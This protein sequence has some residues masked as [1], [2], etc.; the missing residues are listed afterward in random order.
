MTNIAILGRNGM[1]GNTMFKYYQNCQT[2]ENT[3]IGKV[4][5][6]GREQF[7]ALKDSVDKLSD[8]LKEEQIDL[9]INAIGMIPQ[10]Y[11]QNETKN[12]K[13]YIRVN[14]VFPHLLAN[15]CEKLNIK[16][17]HI[18]TDCVFSG[19][20]DIT[21]SYTEDSDHDVDYIY[22]LT[23]SEG[24]P[25]NC[26]VVRTSIIGHELKHKKSLLEWVIS[27]TNK[28]INGYANHYWNG[29][30]CLQLAKILDP[31]KNQFENKLYHV[32][33]PN[34]VSKYELVN[35]INDIYKLNITINSFED[36]NYCNRTLTSLHPH[37]CINTIP[38][39][40]NQI[41][42]THDFGM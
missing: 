2:M 8:M 9:V 15:L 28:T 13:S 18:T 26:T 33:S 38:S 11:T 35:M 42:E 16:C 4:I 10:K 40:Y 3:N 5:G 27:Q 25:T 21:K 41:E 32:Y 39:L 12:I 37:N 36:K 20:L 19:K 22:G 6:I 29:V 30:T 14:S 23:K 31:N 34:V 17:I 1:L 7:D 24:E